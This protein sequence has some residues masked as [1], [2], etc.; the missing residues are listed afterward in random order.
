MGLPSE[1][2]EAYLRAFTSARPLVRKAKASAS[3]TDAFIKT[4][5]RSNRHV[6]AFNGPLH[7]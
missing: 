3:L 7:G 5:A 1:G 2:C 6:Q 4:D